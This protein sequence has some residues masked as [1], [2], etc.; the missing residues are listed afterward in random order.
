ML[1]PGRRVCKKTG[2]ARTTC[3]V[4]LATPLTTM[5]S[6]W[7]ERDEEDQGKETRPGPVVAGIGMPSLRASC[8]GDPCA[9]A[10]LWLRPNRRRRPQQVQAAA[11]QPQASSGGHPAAGY[12][13]HAGAYAS[14]CSSSLS[15]IV[16]GP[17]GV[18]DAVQYV[19]AAGALCVQAGG[20][21]RA[22]PPGLLPVARDGTRAVAT[23][24][25]WLKPPLAVA[26]GCWLA[27][28][29]R[30]GDA[31][32]FRSLTHQRARARLRGSGTVPHP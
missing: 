13:G 24:A 7:S 22:T 10:I 4:Q 21:R 26:A 6:T 16:L 25:G 29:S 27:K 23:H 12:D 32:G 15:N 30:R 11:P 31:Q 8:K 19:Q 17:C 28:K 3:A 1:G 5:K 20:G 2:D 18:D 14:M 9:H